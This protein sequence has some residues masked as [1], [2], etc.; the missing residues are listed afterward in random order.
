MTNTD[1]EPNYET[2]A[3]THPRPYFARSAFKRY[4]G[5]VRED[6]ERKE[7]SP[8]CDHRCAQANGVTWKSQV[9]AEAN[10]T[11]ERM[12]THATSNRAKARKASQTLQLEYSPSNPNS[13]PTSIPGTH[14]KTIAVSDSLDLSKNMSLKSTEPSIIKRRSKQMQ[15]SREEIQIIPPEAPLKPK[16]VAFESSA[17]HQYGEELYRRS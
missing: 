7:L 1:H 5:D 11:T 12:E 6:Y 9:E 14:R 16:G 3:T 4:I 13:I 15:K 10:A 8:G 2:I 17:G